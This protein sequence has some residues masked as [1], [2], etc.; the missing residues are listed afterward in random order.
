MFIKSLKNRIDQLTARYQHNKDGTASIEFVLI[1]PLLIF[2]YIGLYEVSIAFTVNGAVNRSSEVAASFPTFEQNLDDTIMSNIMTAT[3]AT[4]DY[5][6]FDITKAAVKIYS[7]EQVGATPASRRLVGQAV[8]EGSDA[9]GILADLTAAEFQSSLGSLQAGDGF[10]VAEV[11]Y[12]Y[13]PL[14]SDLYIDQ[15]TLTD[16]KLLNPRENQGA[17]LPIE[18]TVTNSGTG[19]A[20]VHPRS[21]LGCNPTDGV[22]S[23]SFSAALP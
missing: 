14:I 5:P 12:L 10:I 17:A 2:L 22:F 20:T 19:G 13:T 1:A 9:T 8:Y 21:V 7:I 16:R 3:I 18:T 23:C 11:A 15:I 6:N 4:L